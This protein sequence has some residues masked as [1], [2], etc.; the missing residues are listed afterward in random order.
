[1]KALKEDIQAAK[2]NEF[3]RKVF[4]AFEFRLHI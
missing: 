1:M 2:E 3:G 4:E